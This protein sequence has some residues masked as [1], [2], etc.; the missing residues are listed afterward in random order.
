MIE[1]FDQDLKKIGILDNVIKASVKREINQLWT[2]EVVLPSDDPKTALC[3]H[4]NFMDIYGESGR[5]YGKYRIVPTKTKKSENDN[6]ITYELEHVLST[7]LDDVIEG[8]L[9]ALIN[10][11]TSINIQRILDLQTVK[12]W[13]LGTCEFD[14]LFQY[15]FEN[16]NG[17]LAPLL[18]IPKPFTDPYEWTFDTQ[19][20]PFKLNLV[21]ASHEVK[22]DI[23]WGRDMISFDEVSD[24]TEIVNYIIPK[25]AGE[26]VN[27]T[28]ITS[29]NSGDNFLKDQQSIDRWGIKKYIW[30]DKR[31]KDPATLKA[32]AQS[33]L[34]QWK[35]PKISFSI[36][37]ADLSILPEFKH[38][39]KLLNGITNIIVGDKQYQGRIISEDIK[40]L[41]KEF[42]VRYEINNQLDDIATTQTD[43]ERKIQVQQAYSQGSTNMNLIPFNENCDPNYPAVIKFPFPDD[44]VHVNEAKLRIE[45]TEFRGYTRG[46]KSAGSYTR[47]EQVQGSVTE[48][49][50]QVVKTETTSSTAPHR[51]HVFSFMEYNNA[52]PDQDGWNTYAFQSSYQ[53]GAENYISLPSSQEIYTY[54]ADGAHSH[55]LTFTIPGH[56]HP[57]SITIPALSIPGH[58]HETEHGIWLNDTLPNSLTVKIDGQTVAFSGLEG[59]ID[60]TDYLA[61]DSDG[62]VSRGY[63]TVEVTPDDLARIEL[64]LQTRFFIQSNTGTQ[65]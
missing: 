22:A 9:P 37:S 54:S 29:V 60:I 4:Y 35:D 23:R 63:H 47:S 20:Y 8:Y 13:E 56:S 42:D 41:S 2:A 39:R 38:T 40:D 6:T 36:D 17:L 21:K 59:E 64:M 57:F 49:N 24:P 45:A 15:H 30:Q 7:L 43:M 32:N 31:F 33:L 27:Q 48:S 51:H 14:F 61:R 25:G 12:H 28:N 16:E 3:S 55:S 62:K 50:D 34:D 19:T 11:P 53:G 65:L 10:Q 1:V 18:S 46:M 44:M 58:I 26:G 5:Y 52:P